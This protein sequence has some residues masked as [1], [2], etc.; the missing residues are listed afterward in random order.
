MNGKVIIEIRSVYGNER[1]YPANDVA[2]VFANIAGTKTL[3]RDVL[4]HAQNLGFEI[5]IVQ[6]KVVL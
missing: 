4:K 3:S 5:E 1:I 2:D 6:P